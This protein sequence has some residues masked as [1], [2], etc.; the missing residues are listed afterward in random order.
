M[1]TSRIDIRHQGLGLSALVLGLGLGCLLTTLFINNIAV[2]KEGVRVID[3]DQ[4]MGYAFPMGF[5]GLGG[6]SVSTLMA[7]AIEDDRKRLANS[8]PDLEKQ[9]RLRRFKIAHVLTTLV[10]SCC[11]ASFVTTLACSDTNG[12]L[13]GLNLQNS[14]WGGLTM[15]GIGAAPLLAAKIHTM[16]V[17]RRAKQHNATSGSINQT[18]ISGTKL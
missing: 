3:E 18:S 6:L 9:A 7:L 15:T 11:F 16:V 5:V 10:A 1:T 17:R 12:T 2:F 4:R 8:E 13:Y 14:F